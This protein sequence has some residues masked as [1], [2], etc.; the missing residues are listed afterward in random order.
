[1]KNGKKVISIMIPCYNEEENARPIYE[2]VRD[3]LISSCPN[4]DYEIL[5]IDNKS[6]DRT[7]EIIE[8]ICARDKHVKA[9]FNCKNFGQFNSPYY[10][11]T[12]T[13]G[14]CTITICA[15]FQDPVELI[16]RFVAEWEKGYKI[17]IGRK[18]R[19]QESKIMYFLR[20]CYYKLIRSMSNVEM[21]EQFTGF[22]LYD[23][24]FVETLRSLKDPTPFIRGIVAE[25]GPERKEIEYEQPKRRAGKTHNNFMSLYDAA[26]LSFTSYTKAGMRI[27]TFLGF[28]IAF[29][30]FIVALGYLI[31]KLC[32]WN[33]FTAGYAPMMIAIFFMGG[34]QLAFL[35]FLGEYVMNMNTRLMNRPL[36]VE[37][38]R[39]NFDE[40]VQSNARRAG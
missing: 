13:S 23:K 40:D 32:M 24:S 38:K 16:P 30:S 8:D 28:I 34:V 3:E 5:F 14:D 33:R 36:V 11:I 31:A 7:R 21:I 9:I 25:L 39:I 15:D 19:S 17:V 35:G 6:Q 22:G 1:M 12:Q 20:G 4:Y 26:M 2:A 27:A 29:L 37:E 10:G 18:T